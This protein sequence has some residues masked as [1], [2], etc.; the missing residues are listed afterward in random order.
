MN[1]APFFI[2]AP[3]TRSS[4]LFETARY[5][6]EDVFNLKPLDG[7]TELFLEYSRNAEFYD[8]KVDEYH[9]A[10]LYPIAHEGNLKVHY[11]YPHV[12]NTRNERNLHKIRILKDL[13][14][15]GHEFNIK[16]T[17]NIVEGYK[18]ILNFYSDRHFV[19]TKRRNT[20]DYVCSLLYAYTSKLFHARPNNLERYR[21][22]MDAG[23]TV[24]Q[25]LLNL[26][27]QL[28]AQTIELWNVQEFIKSNN[29]TCTVTYYEDLDTQENI[30]TTITKILGTDEWKK[31]LPE[32]ILDKVP[33]KIDKDYSKIISN[34]EEVIPYI[35]KCIKESK[36]ELSL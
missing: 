16:G 10:E 25:E 2:S 28:L 5:Y 33:L 9:T 30:D 13:K 35:R 22:I 11:I 4:V 24:S 3:R 6:V 12:F 21:S 7:H 23:I 36:I 18:E 29:C 27:P 1:K 26:V 17:I 20:E 8:V 14:E 15:Q 34:Y 32:N 19:I 31:Y